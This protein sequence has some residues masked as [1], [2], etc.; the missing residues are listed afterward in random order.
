MPKH[1]ANPSPHTRGTHHLRGSHQNVSQHSSFSST[2]AGAPSKP[3]AGASPYLSPPAA[4]P[5]ALG[6][7]AIDASNSISIEETVHKAYLTNRSIESN[8]AGQPKMGVDRLERKRTGQLQPAKRT[9]TGTR[10]P[11]LTH[12]VGHLGSTAGQL[13]DYRQVVDSSGAKP[14]MFSH[15]RQPRSKSKRTVHAN[16]TEA[17]AHGGLECGILSLASASD[18]AGPRSSSMHAFPGQAG[19]PESASPQ[20]L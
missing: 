6:L 12:E 19:V 1:D 2:K 17:E 10:K 3:V 15:S 7:P 20:K 18:R 9:P 11:G 13:N 14:A 5:R 16:M 4:P 8:G